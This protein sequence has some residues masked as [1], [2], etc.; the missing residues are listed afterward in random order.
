[1][2]VSTQSRSAVLLYRVYFCSSS[3]LPRGLF[4]K[5]YFEIPWANLRAAV[6]PSFAER[7]VINHNE[8]LTNG[9]L[10]TSSAISVT[11]TEVL[12]KDGRLIPY[13]YL[14]IATGHATSPPRTREERLRQF[15][16]GA[17]PP[18]LV[19]LPM[20]SPDG[21]VILLHWKRMSSADSQIP[22]QKTRR[23]GRPARF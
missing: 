1:M 4:R 8:Y 5:E 2:R 14:V 23:Y 21:A 16:E 10:V 18:Q 13:D 11:E 9:R 22:P 19:C 17:R 20:Q 6:E 7:S 12:T 3:A 15:Q